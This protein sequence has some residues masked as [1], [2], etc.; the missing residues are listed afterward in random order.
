[1][2][3]AIFK[4]GNG[5]SYFG[6]WCQ[7]LNCYFNYLIPGCLNACLLLYLNTSNS[8]SYQFTKE[9]HNYL[10]IGLLI[11]AIYFAM[12]SSIQMNIILA[13]YS[14]VQLLLNHL[15]KGEIFIQTKQLVKEWPFI[16]I[17]IFWLLSLIF[18]A[19]GGRAADVGHNS[20][21]VNAI[22]DVSL[23]KDVLEFYAE[24]SSTKPRCLASLD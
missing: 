18:D 12:F 21:L 22:K 13:S 14:I 9:N 24:G 11:V 4:K 20:G 17:I 19:N 10:T 5:E 1:M 2:Q 16:L 6:F 23:I 3:S 15:R 7:D 8:E